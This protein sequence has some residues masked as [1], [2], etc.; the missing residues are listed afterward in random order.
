VIQIRPRSVA[1]VVAIVLAFALAL[2]IV[3]IAGQVIVWIFIA[4]FLALAINP[5]VD[6]LQAR[7]VHRRG[8]AV[9]LAFGAVLVAAVGVAAVFVPILV[10][11]IG[12]FIDAVPGYI[13]DLTKGKG[14]LGFLE[15]DYHVVEKVEKAIK[16]NSAGKVIGFSNVALSLTKGVLSAIVA[17]ITITF[18]TLFMLLEGPSWIDRFFSLFSEETSRRW[19]S[20]GRD[21]YRT[22]GGY[23][24]GNILISLIAGTLATI[25]LW[26]LGVPYPVPLGLLVA[27][28][29]LVPLAGA[30]VAAVIITGIA[31]T[32][33]VWAGVIVLVYFVIYQQVE[34]QLLQ[35]VIYGKTVQ[36]SPLAVL[37]AVLIGAKLGGIVGALAAIPVA[38]AIQI[39]LR[40]L[41][42][43]RVS[44]ASA[45]GS[46]GKK[47]PALA[48]PDG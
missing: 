44:A 35:P 11:Q 1:L 38:G 25:V 29:D 7:G 34:N 39:V 12:N 43:N 6:W 13:K 16:H 15:S 2:Q 47:R 45:S 26:A 41:L 46:R 37:I 23:V 24:A 9:A 21:V 40:D 17:A 3:F 42:Q 48:H 8:L 10:D 18:M 4:L 30:T 33:G 27:L 14:P 19:R 31:F 28:L 32:T 22:V 20:V 36:L 5:L